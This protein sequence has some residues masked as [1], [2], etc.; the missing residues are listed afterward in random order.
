MPPCGPLRGCYAKAAS[1]SGVEGKGQNE[2]H[3]GS[4]TYEL[5]PTVLCNSCLG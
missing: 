2:R 5:A 1:V 4:V 3:V